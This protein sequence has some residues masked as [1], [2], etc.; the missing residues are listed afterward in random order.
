M[1]QALLTCLIPWLLWSAQGT[2]S[3]DRVYDSGAASEAKI[4]KMLAGLDIDHFV[5]S[6]VIDWTEMGT[7]NVGLVP[8]PGFAMCYDEPAYIGDYSMEAM[9]VH[10]LGIN[11][12]SDTMKNGYTRGEDDSSIHG[13]GYANVI[14]FPVIGMVMGD[15]GLCVEGSGLSIPYMA[16]L[17]P[18]YDGIFSHNVFAEIALLFNPTAMLT[19]AIDCMASSIAGLT[20]P[21][22]AVSQKNDEIRMGLPHYVGCW[23]SFPMGGWSHNPNPLLMGA[24]STTYGLAMG[25]RT[26]AIKKSFR[27]K[28]LDGGLYKDTMCGPKIE[29]KF[30]K[31]QYLYNMFYPTVS[32]T[33]P[34]GATAQEWAE[35]KQ[36]GTGADK[37]S[38]WIFKRK[39][40]YFGAAS[41][42]SIK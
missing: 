40:F 20:D 13:F 32:E 25:Q 2:L 15:S 12:G 16:W 29:P 30:V 33:V 18:T 10:S 9:E 14:T 26:G 37:S 41:C 21:F 28:G 11:F 35:F 5:E 1:K 36:D 42:S 3:Y 8:T 4:D 38:F 27:L 7:C 34:L 24:T 19:G 17:D 31:V 6:I 39:C 23:N 22:T